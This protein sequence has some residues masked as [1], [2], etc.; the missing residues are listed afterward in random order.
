MEPLEGPTPFPHHY[1][2]S[3]RGFSTSACLQPT[4][5]GPTT[6]DSFSFPTKVG[7]TPSIIFSSHQVWPDSSIL[8]MLNIQKVIGISNAWCLGVLES[9]MSKE[10]SIVMDLLSKTRMVDDWEE[11]SCWLDRII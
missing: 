7:C 3:V 11:Y 9:K 10:A 2:I 4:R 6:G 8:V 5:D 1:K